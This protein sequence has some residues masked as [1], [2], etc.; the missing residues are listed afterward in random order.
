MEQ[1]ISFPGLGLEFSIDRVAFHIG[2]RPVYWYGVLIALGFLLAVF[3]VMGKAKTFGL[4]SDRAF[5]VTFITVVLGIIGARLFY[6]AFM[7]DDYKDN[8]KSIFIV[9]NGG[10]AIYGG[11]IF[12]IIGVW[13]GC[14]ARKV[15]TLPMYDLI[16][17]GVFIGQAIGRWGNFI[18]MEAFGSNT[19]LPWGMTSQSIHNYLAYHQSSLAEL[20]VFVDPMQPVHPTFLYESIWCL[21][22]FIVL[23][24]LTKRRRFDGQL[25]LFYLGWYGFGRF[26]I[27]GLRTDSLLVSSF[28]VSQ[29]IALITFAFASITTF[30][31]LHNIKKHNDPNYIPLYVNTEESKLVLSGKFYKEKSAPTVD[32]IFEEADSAL[33][34]TDNRDIVEKAKD[35]LEEEI[36]S[37]G[38][39][40]PASDKTENNTE[41]E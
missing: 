41:G 19:S 10:L 18:N 37:L 1:T 8:L 24:F 38:G 33:E 26:F 29:L 22:G 17:G 2:S 34:E 15:K 13:I 20:G 40:T 11:I 32:E 23:L 27:E 9:S 5:D 7:W 4:D 14:R 31:V 3:Y 35:T 6:V 39:D 21:L 16:V 12:G 36:K 28:R 25:T 30:V